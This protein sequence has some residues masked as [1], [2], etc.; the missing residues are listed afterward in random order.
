MLA[1]ML[2]GMAVLGPVRELLVPGLSARDDVMAL[3]MATDM[4][5]GMAVWM[6]VRRSSWSAIGEMSAAMYVPF[7]VLLV[8]YWAGSL[9]GDALLT[10]GH[11]LM[12]PAMAVPLVRGRHEHA[13]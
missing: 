11:V 12:L 2:V 9:P 13:C 10:W 8:P 4:A 5:V 3:L 6:R 7:L 1:A